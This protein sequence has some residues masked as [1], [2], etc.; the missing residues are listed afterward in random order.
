MALI[1]LKKHE[2]V[3]YF[4]EQNVLSDV[5]RK[6]KEICENTVEQ[7]KNCD[8]DEKKELTEKLIEHM[9]KLKYFQKELN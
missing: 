4:A 5:V 8:Q 2:A 9:A 3:K 7:W 6:E 1:A